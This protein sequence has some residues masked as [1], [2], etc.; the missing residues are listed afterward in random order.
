MNHISTLPP[1]DTTD[2][3]TINRRSSNVEE[4]SFTRADLNSSL[5]KRSINDLLAMF[6]NLKSF[7][8]EP[9]DPLDL[10]RKY[11]TFEPDRI[12]SSLLLYAGHSLTRLKLHARCR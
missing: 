12:C 7:A 1:E 10:E 6:K 9:C 8:Y 5:R 4:L 3:E 11:Y 2:V